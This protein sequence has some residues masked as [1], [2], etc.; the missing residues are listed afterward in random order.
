[1][2]HDA[3][4]LRPSPSPAGRGGGVTAQ[5]VTERVRSVTEGVRSVTEGVRS[6]TEGVKSAA[7]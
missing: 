3:C 2:L 6:V 7:T 1:M 4:E 5:A